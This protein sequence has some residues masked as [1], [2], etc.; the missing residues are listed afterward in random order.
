MYEEQQGNLSGRSL[1]SIYA[2]LLT[3]IDESQIVRLGDVNMTEFDSTSSQV[4]ERLPA[5]I[6]EKLNDDQLYIH[7]NLFIK[8]DKDG[9]G[10]V[11]SDE[12]KSMLEELGFGD[13]NHDDCVAMIADLDADDTGNISFEEFN[14]LLI[15]LM[16][17]D[18]DKVKQDGNER[19]DGR[20]QFPT[21]L[22]HIWT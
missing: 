20:E 13:V 22:G 19:V 11:D 6:R 9:S 15:G 12:L 3:S 7:L 2:R 10:Y 18:R 17:D 21:N 4:I 16:Y 14:D 5:H 8:F 1:A